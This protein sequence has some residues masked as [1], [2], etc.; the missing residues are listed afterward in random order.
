[1][2]VTLNPE[3][4]EVLRAIVRRYVDTAADEVAGGGQL[5]TTAK[6]VDL[7]GHKLLAAA[8]V[9]WLI[10]RS[11]GDVEADL[12]ITLREN[13]MY[14]AECATTDVNAERDKDL[15]ELAVIDALVA[16]LTEG[17]T[18]QCASCFKAA[19]Q[20]WG[21]GVLAGDTPTLYCDECAVKMVAEDGGV[22][23]NAVQ[24]AAHALATIREE[25][26][27]DTELRRLASRVLDDVA[28]D[29]CDADGSYDVPAFTMA[30]RFRPIG[31]QA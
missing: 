23:Y 17:P 24:V 14:L 26:H 31:G 21:I 3:Q 6:T 13:A 15:R 30:P 7:A 22:I 9:A 2:Q 18:K 29:Q 8:R 12:L 4:A 19:T 16:Q 1:M 10:E 28:T 25:L 20:Q 27:D 5:V 11:G